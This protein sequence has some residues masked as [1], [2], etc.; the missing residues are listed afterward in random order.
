MPQQKTQL[1]SQLATWQVVIGG[2][3]DPP[4]PLHQSQ[5]TMWQVVSQ[6]VPFVVE[7]D[8]SLQLCTP[9]LRCQNFCVGV[10]FEMPMLAKRCALIYGFLRD[11]H[12][13]ADKT[14]TF[15]RETCI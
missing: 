14:S 15:F 10:S 13:L 5:L 1:V 9:F 7:L 4:S 8:F 2:R 3:V 12:A 11:A 6:I